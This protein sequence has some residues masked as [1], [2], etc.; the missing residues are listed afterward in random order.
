[1]A[2][3][4]IEHTKKWLIESVI[5]YQFCPYAKPPHQAN[6]IAYHVYT[7]NDIITL[8]EKL[9]YCCI[10]LDQQ[11][12]ER[13]ETTLLIVANEHLE[14]DCVDYLGDFYDY[15]DALDVATD[16]LAR[17]KDFAIHFSKDFQQHA[18][19]T[20][21][22]SWQEKYQLASFHPDYIFENTS[23]NDRENYTNRS[24]YPIFHLIRNASIEQV[25]IDDEQANKVVERNIATL[26]N[27]SDEAFQLLRKIT[28]AK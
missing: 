1:M 14:T 19:K 18:D 4:P 25:R 3:T 23:E 26:E 7:G 8:L 27:L 5:N 20:L 12:P 15:L 9:A 21:P 24:P 6:R 16:F 13:L 17:P 22:E 2:T 28:Q 10:E 11:P